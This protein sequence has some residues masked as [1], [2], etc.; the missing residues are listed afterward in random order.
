MFQVERKEALKKMFVDSGEYEFE[1]EEKAQSFVSDVLS[2]AENLY[3]EEN[4]YR[5]YEDVLDFLYTHHVD[6]IAY[7]VYEEEYAE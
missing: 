3:S 4:F 2:E 5:E 7:H 6:S 1:N